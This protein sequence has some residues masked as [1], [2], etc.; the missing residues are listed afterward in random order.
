MWRL[1]PY[2]TTQR[3]ENK[4]IAS[5]IY[6]THSQN[7]CAR[8]LWPF[9]QN[10]CCS[11]T[12]SKSL[13]HT[14]SSPLILFNFNQT[15]DTTQQLNANW[16]RVRELNSMFAV[17]RGSSAACSVANSAAHS[18][19]THTTRGLPASPIGFVWVARRQLQ[20]SCCA[21]CWCAWAQE[22]HFF[23]SVR[24]RSLSLFLWL[25]AC[26]TLP[27]PSAAAFMGCSCCYCWLMP[28][29]Q[30]LHAALGVCVCILRCGRRIRCIRSLFHFPIIPFVGKTPL[31]LLRRHWDFSKDVYV[32]SA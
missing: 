29:L 26:N 19:D 12:Q 31:L 10:S 14:L 11:S 20:H 27:A 6:F 30:L 1:S 9:N 13:L 8:S 22:S 4:Q 15:N 24:S 32:S 21:V 18:P 16:T 25:C 7:V 3:F 17:E 28:R 2:I 5:N 23:A